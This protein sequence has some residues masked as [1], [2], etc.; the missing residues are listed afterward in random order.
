MWL[1]SL[2]MSAQNYHFTWE[3][4]ISG[5]K[6]VWAANDT[7]NTYYIPELSMNVKV[8]IIDPFGQNTTLGNM[9]E[10]GDYTQTNTFFGSGNLALQ[11]TSEY[12]GQSVCLKFEFE[13]PVYIRDFK[14][15]DID[16][17]QDGTW[18][19]NTFQDSIMVIANRNEVNIPLFLSHMSTSP[20]YTIYGQTI[21]AN[22]FPGVNGDVDYNDLN[23][24]ISVSSASPVTEFA[25]YHSNGSQDDGISNSHA[26]KIPGFDIELFQSPLPV[27]I[28][29]LHVS[30]REKDQYILSWIANSEMNNDYYTI[31]TSSDGINFTK[32]GVLK[33][34]N[35]SNH[36]YYFHFEISDIPILFIKLEQTDFDG[37]TQ[38]LGIVDI[39]NK[40]DA[41]IIKL[42]STIV[43]DILQLD[44]SDTIDNLYRWEI[45]DTQGR[46][47]TDGIISKGEKT[48]DAHA[49]MS[50]TY[51][52]K[53]SSPSSTKAY[54]FVKL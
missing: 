19:P 44:V 34:Q 42:R 43:S 5:I 17:K 31:S 10:F 36:Q 21:R 49:L 9:S 39:K 11:A 6:A 2:N 16:M 41:K 24:A 37:T 23:G 52:L 35:L 3:G 14:I 20:S 18:A 53:V 48:I 25:L 47:I 30:K 40:V 12:S 46:H 27:N 29:D 38:M 51:T 4:A 7:S 45:Y 28:S 26:I 33:S 22:L 8:S 50:G 15:Y 1:A 32:Y 54:K 13:K